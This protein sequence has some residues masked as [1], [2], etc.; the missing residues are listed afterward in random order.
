MYS[1]YYM[2]VVVNDYLNII[3]LGKMNLEPVAAV[4]FTYSRGS[5]YLFPLVGEHQ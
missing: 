1:V 2:F 5:L 4:L 3:P